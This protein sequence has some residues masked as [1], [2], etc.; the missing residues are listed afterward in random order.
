MFQIGQIQC[1]HFLPAFA[2]NSPGKSRVGHHFFSFLAFQSGPG[3]NQPNTEGVCGET[4][5]LTFE[6]VRCFFLLVVHV[7]PESQETDPWDLKRV[8]FF[9][10]ITTKLL[11]FVGIFLAPWQF[12]W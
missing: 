6:V 4:T 12:C 1:R 10:G 9:V 3:F 5:E 8:P 7:V 11:F 2:H